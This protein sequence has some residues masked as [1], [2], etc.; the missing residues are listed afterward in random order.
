MQGPTRSAAVRAAAACLVLALGAC[1]A[2][3][4]PRPGACAAMDTVLRPLVGAARDTG[5]AVE[6]SEHAVLRPAAGDAGFW[7]RVRD[8]GF[9]PVWRDGAT[10]TALVRAYWR[11]WRAMEP[12]ERAGQAAAD[13]RGWEAAYA[14]VGDDRLY[15]ADALWAAFFSANGRTVR[16][17]CTVRF[18][19]AEGA[20]LVGPGDP[21]AVNAVRFS[22]A[23][24]GLAGDRALISAWSVYPP[25]ED[26]EPR[27]TG[28][29]WLLTASGRSW[30]VISAS[31]V[32]G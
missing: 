19:E 10:E 8:F 16:W 9:T 24:P 18:A 28:T 26:G 25:L 5:H 15:P 23:R 6:L 17:S 7:R 11:N 32:E 22:V 31:R 4:E 13:R 3:P 30:R 1:A 20:R 2:G 21:R 27:E 12:R 14:E 29:I